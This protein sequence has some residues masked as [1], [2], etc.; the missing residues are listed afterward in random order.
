MGREHQPDDAPPK[1]TADAPSNGGR[2][3]L[4]LGVAL[5][6]LATVARLAWVLAVPTVPTSD[7]AMYRESAN[8]LSELGWLDHGFIYMPGYVL[9]LA[10]VQSAGGD[11]LAQKLIGVAC[12][13]VGA[14][15]IFWLALGLFQGNEGRRVAVISTLIYALWPAGVAM[16]SVVGT[17][18]PA[19]SFVVA[20]LGAL[21]ALGPRRPRAAAVAFGALMGVAAW[22]R[23]VA[24]PLSALSIGY[25]LARGYWLE[26]RAS[27]RAALA[28]TAIGVATTLLVL[29]PWGVF[30]VRRT[31]HLYFTDDHGGITAIVGSF[32]N[33]EGTYARSL[34]KMFLELT[35]R[36]VL[37]EPH[38]E[39]DKLALDLARDWT[40]FEPAY[41]LGL[42]TKRLERFFDSER[43]L[44]YWPIFRPGV[45]VGREGAWF[46]ARESSI[47]GA[48]DVF[49]A[50]VAALAAAGVAIALVRRRWLALTL[51]PHALALTATYTLFFA[52]PR[53]RLPVEMLAFPFAAYALV[54]LAAFFVAIA[55]RA[56]AELRARGPAIA[57]AAA[58]VLVGDLAWGAVDGVGE[59]LRERHRW[60]ATV[61]RADGAGRLAKWKPVDTRAARS[62]VLGLADGVRISTDGAGATAVAV[63][64]DLGAAPLAP[65]SY[66]IELE[67]TTT[68]PVTLRLAS[69]EGA[70][71]VGGALVPATP[72]TLRATFA[73]AGGPLGATATLTSAAPA[74]V[75]VNAM[76]I[77]RLTGS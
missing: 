58:V 26:R 42:A 76:R 69:P 12:G 15:G 72:F 1:L 23:A 53:Y 21:A 39:T 20:A 8:H 66:V 38:H 75:T 3:T 27:W 70:Q 14:A 4:W 45:L 73:H 63:Y 25:W 57:I 41:S 71:L 32:P 34:N 5:V 31:G 7:F 74:A 18:M 30:H 48:V 43:Y 9:L 54:E 33:S 64:V 47:G 65:G 40:T 22:M 55:R 19:A 10:A 56:K 49:G 37:A 2:A 16:S 61:W 29:A 67:G 11:L 59:A 17:D 36:S 24:L 44:L 46:A 68:A 60:A 35:G 62:P 77:D 52:E 28:R 51:V 50:L 13:G 6:A